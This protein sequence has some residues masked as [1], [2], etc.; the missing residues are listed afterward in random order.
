LFFGQ[1]LRRLPGGLL[2]LRV[3]EIW[4]L[5]RVGEANFPARL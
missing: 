2:R 1:P 5:S 3:E 4:Y